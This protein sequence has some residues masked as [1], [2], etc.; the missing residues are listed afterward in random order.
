MR[1][2]LLLLLLALP[3]APALAADNLKLN[4]HLDY[5][6]DSQDGPLI[7]GDHMDEATV[8]GKPSYVIVYAEACFNSK[9]QAR[10][11]VSLYEKYKG[12][13]QFVVLDL[14]LKRTPE[15]QKLIDRFNQGYIPHVVL[16]GKKGEVLY[17]RAGEVEEADL[18]KIL[19]KAVEQVHSRQ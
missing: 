9:R 16:L 15:Q 19:D 12:R 5:Q 8:A 13:V 2:L 3:A 4:D 14:D 17:D 18:A 6:T 11:T 1:H 10:R 7:T